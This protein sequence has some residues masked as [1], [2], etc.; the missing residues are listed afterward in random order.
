M[1]DKEL[2]SETSSE[3]VLNQTL[4]T[5]LDKNLNNIKPRLTTFTSKNLTT[6]EVELNKIRED[7]VKFQTEAE[8]KNRALNKNQ[9]NSKKPEAESITEAMTEATK[10]IKEDEV[11]LIDEVNTEAELNEKEVELE[12]N[13]VE[14]EVAEIEVEA[15]KDAQSNET[16]KAYD[17][18]AWKEAE[19]EFKEKRRKYI[20]LR[21]KNRRKI[22]EDVVN[23]KIEDEALK[24]AEAEAEAKEN[25]IKIREMV[26]TRRALAEAKAE[27]EKA[28]A[29][30]EKK[31]E[32]AA[33]TDAEEARY[34]LLQA[35]IDK[36][37]NAD[38][39]I[40]SN[41][42]AYQA[43]TSA[44]EA[45]KREIEA[46]INK[47]KPD[48][49]AK[50]EVLKER[51]KVARQKAFRNRT[52]EFLRQN[53][54]MFTEKGD[55]ERRENTK[56]LILEKNKLKELEVSISEL[57]GTSMNSVQTN[58]T[59]SRLSTSVNRPPVLDKESRANLTRY[60]ETLD[61][62]KVGGNP[63]TRTDVLNKLIGISAAILTISKDGSKLYDILNKE[64]FDKNSFRT[65]IEN[66]R[67]NL[68]LTDNLQKKKKELNKILSAMR[69]R[70]GITEE[71]VIKANAIK[72]GYKRILRYTRRKR[73][74]KKKTN[75]FFKR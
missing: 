29:E 14:L 52:F 57:R 17:E 72:G 44:A 50:I 19:D 23:K 6:K 33:L 53:P 39:K 21:V 47:L 48:I 45:K 35:S 70:F 67:I 31:I 4:L 54:N 65:T 7:R 73:R 38:V 58:P 10:K 8:I 20:E 12:F 64:M 3:K 9:E 56:S 2:A 71:D 68:N 51:V 36:V 49:E 41:T 5:E 59:R 75:K 34:I 40:D 30:E 18:T 16:S 63:K 60:L 46:R 43:L 11:A 42:T 74:Y 37:K 26:K 28:Q 69:V 13:N 24:A 1:L 61:E 15:I 27:L 55:E 32:E 62:E 22:A 25:T 66:Y